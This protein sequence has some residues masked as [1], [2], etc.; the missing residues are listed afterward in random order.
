MTGE[1]HATSASN[2]N[3]RNSSA[4]LVAHLYNYMLSRC[5]GVA[6]PGES[7]QPTAIK[8]LTAVTQLTQVSP[9]IPPWPA[10]SANFI[11]SFSFYKVS[12]PLIR[13]TRTERKRARPVSRCHCVRPGCSMPNGKG[14][15]ISQLVCSERNRHE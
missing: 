9:K 5:W 4:R 10:N 12:P 6:K 3:G 14:K 8:H 1:M 13:F 11:E 15:L 7:T 2:T